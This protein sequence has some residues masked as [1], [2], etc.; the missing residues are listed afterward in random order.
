MVLLLATWPSLVFWS[1]DIHLCTVLALLKGLLVKSLGTFNA[2]LADNILLPI[3]SL[4]LYA[5]GFEVL[6]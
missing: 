1:A 6:N 3:K 2:I 5:R 4:F